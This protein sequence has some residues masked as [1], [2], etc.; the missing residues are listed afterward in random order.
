MSWP[1][2]PVSGERRLA[3]DAAGTAAVP[4][5]FTLFEILVVF[6]VLGLALVLVTGFRPPWSRGLDIEATAA[7][8]ASQLRLVRSEAIVR[9]RPAALELDLAGRRYRP[10]AGAARP[11]PNGLTIDLL[12]IAGERPGG[13][14]GAIRFHPDGSSTGGRI[15]LADGLRQVA[16]GVDWLTGRVSV[17]DVE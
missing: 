7:E 10:G 9:N 13:A 16:V 17:A 4:G 8:L 5:G 1:C 2:N 15:V 3:R 12:T 11:L 6:A 14:E